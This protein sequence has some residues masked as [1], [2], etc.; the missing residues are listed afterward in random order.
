M[1]K[2]FFPVFGVPDALANVAK[3]GSEIIPAVLSAG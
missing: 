3:E 2:E 1:Q